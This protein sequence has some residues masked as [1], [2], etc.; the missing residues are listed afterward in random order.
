[1]RTKQSVRI[2]FA[3]LTWCESIRFIDGYDNIIH[4]EQV[5]FGGPFQHIVKVFLAFQI[6][7]KHLTI[8]GLETYSPFP[9]LS[10]EDF[11]EKCVEKIGLLGQIRVSLLQL[12]LNIPFLT[13]SK[14][15]KR[16]PGKSQP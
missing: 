9:T 10:G 4:I 8:P 11:I 12:Y 3:S 14:W 1:V 6:V 7:S 13:L 2:S 16:I 15:F 5:H